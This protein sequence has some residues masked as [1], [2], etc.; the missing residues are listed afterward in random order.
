MQ[1]FFTIQDESIPSL[2]TYMDVKWDPIASHAVLRISVHNR[3]T[4][5]SQY[6]TIP[7]PKSH[8]WTVRDILDYLNVEIVDGIWAP[9]MS[10]EEMLDTLIRDVPTKLP[11][12]SILV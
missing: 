8:T 11:T 3:K 7:L 4:E 12:L 1:T 2:R 9:N 5:T 6:E 10:Q